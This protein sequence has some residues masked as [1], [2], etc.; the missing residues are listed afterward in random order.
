MKYLKR[1]QDRK[2]NGVKDVESDQ[3]KEPI[4]KNEAENIKARRDA[5]VLE[6]EVQRKKKRMASMSPDDE[7][8][9]NQMNP[10]MPKIHEAENEDKDYS[11]DNKG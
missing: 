9:F 3:P 11:N 4:D 7:F 1:K 6:I 8:R 5:R 10:S 2:R